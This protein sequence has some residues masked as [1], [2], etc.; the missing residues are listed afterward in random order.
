[1]KLH[2]S[3]TS[4]HRYRKS[5]AMWDH[6]VLPATRQRWLSRLYPSRSWVLK[7]THP[8]GM[9]GWV[10]LVSGYNSQDSL[11]A[12]RRSSASEINNQALS[13]TGDEPST[14]ELWVRRPNHS[15]TQPPSCLMFVHDIVMMVCVA[16]YSPNDDL[17]LISE[18]SCQV[19]RDTGRHVNAGAA[20]RSR[21]PATECYHCT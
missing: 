5:H 10:D 4:P 3:E 19:G 17:R 14:L 21:V 12:R 16:R 1:M 15:T 7:F 20:D 6:S 18:G 11:P 13:W 8:G 2:H 9:Q